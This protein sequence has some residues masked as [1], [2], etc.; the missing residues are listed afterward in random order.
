M[1]AE[2][3]AGR[4]ACCRF[5]TPPFH[6]SGFPPSP[7]G[8]W[9][10]RACRWMRSN[11]NRPHAQMSEVAGE[12]ALRIVAAAEFAEGNP[13]CPFLQWHFR[14]LGQKTDGRE[15]ELSMEISH[16]SC[17]KQGGYSGSGESRHVARFSRT[18]RKK[19]GQ[20]EIPARFEFKVLVSQALLAAEQAADATQSEE[21]Q[22][23][24]RKRRSAIGD[25][26]CLGGR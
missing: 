3:S 15:P 14:A 19:N 26:L 17:G 9:Q 10:A 6:G 23:E 16:P 18:F 20:G 11:R 8:R 7:R 1:P 13:E 2:V 21:A 22:S 4:R 5:R 25:R 24:H 12:S